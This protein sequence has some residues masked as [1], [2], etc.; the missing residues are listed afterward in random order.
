MQY[1]AHCAACLYTQGSYVPKTVYTSLLP[2]GTTLTWRVHCSG[3]SAPEQPS[4]QPSAP[5]LTKWTCL[6]AMYQLSQKTSDGF[7]HSR[8]LVREFPVLMSTVTDHHHGKV[9][10]A[11][12]KPLK[13]TPALMELVDRKG[14]YR[15]TAAGVAKAQ[16][17]LLQGSQASN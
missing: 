13:L 11:L 17:L 16:E 9:L 12:T 15:L 10:Y 1:K 6:A 7:V 8:K 2:S 3:D 4:I 5:K 14:L